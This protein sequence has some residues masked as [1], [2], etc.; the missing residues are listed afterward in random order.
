MGLTIHDL[1]WLRLRECDLLI[2]NKNGG[3][4]ISPK[5]IFGFL[6]ARSTDKSLHNF[7][8]F[9]LAGSTDKS[10]LEISLYHIYQRNVFLSIQIIQFIFSSFFAIWGLG[11]FLNFFRMGVC[12]HSYFFRMWVCSRSHFYQMGVCI[13]RRDC[14]MGVTIFREYIR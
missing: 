4:Q 7:F 1:G 2:G 11:I 9:L 3:N 5:N 13:N 10:P 8:G 12:N 14:R 6:L